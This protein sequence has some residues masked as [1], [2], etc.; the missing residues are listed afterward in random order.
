[1]EYAV[2]LGAKPG[3]S[4]VN[5]NC[6]ETAASREGIVGGGRRPR[7]VGA[8]R[9]ADDARIDGSPHRTIDG[10]RTSDEAKECSSDCPT[11]APRYITAK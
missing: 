2:K 8:D 11:P 4:I 3:T 1:M 10:P 6:T 9:W 5:V 7:M